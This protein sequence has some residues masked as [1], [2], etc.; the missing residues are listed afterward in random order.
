MLRQVNVNIYQNKN[1]FTQIRR[2]AEYHFI[3]EEREKKYTQVLTY[4]K[5]SANDDSRWKKAAVNRWESSD[6]FENVY[7]FIT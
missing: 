5:V 7:L 1:T 2:R 6:K 3:E 4:T